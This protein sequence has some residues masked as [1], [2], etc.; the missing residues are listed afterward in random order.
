MFSRRY[1]FKLSTKV[2]AIIKKIFNM[3]YMVASLF[4][5]SMAYGYED[6]VTINGF[7]IRMRNCPSNMRL[8][9]ERADQDFPTLWVTRGGDR[10][11]ATEEGQIAFS[12]GDS[13]QYI[14]TL[15]YPEGFFVGW[16]DDCGMIVI[17]PITLR[18][19]DSMSD[20]SSGDE[21]VPLGRNRP[22]RNSLKAFCNY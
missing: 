14:A 9:V 8:D 12:Y 3:G 1:F 19:T 2:N 21:L 10:G 11:T 7:T 4:A 13:M 17:Y 6:I 22:R 16:N 5:T 18:R 20:L 15:R